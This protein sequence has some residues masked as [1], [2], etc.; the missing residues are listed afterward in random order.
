MYTFILIQVC[1]II[2]SCRITLIH[3]RICIY[4][5][6]LYLRIRTIHICIVIYVKRIQF[7]ILYIGI[8]PEEYTSNILLMFAERGNSKLS[9]VLA[10]DLWAAKN[11][12]MYT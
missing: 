1:I 4:Q 7:R 9:L 5:Y 3:Y 2:Y 8:V 6:I 10:E 11:H 12:L